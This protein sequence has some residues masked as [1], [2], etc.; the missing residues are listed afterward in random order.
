MGG[1]RIPERGWKRHLLLN[2]RYLLA[3]DRHQ[4]LAL[5]PI[6]TILRISFEA[7][8]Q[9]MHHQNGGSSEGLKASPALVSVPSSIF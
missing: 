6:N 1:P 7:Q 5:R 8:L 4:E 2:N 3:K 9:A